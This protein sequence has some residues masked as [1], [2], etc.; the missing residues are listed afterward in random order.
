MKLKAVLF[1][2]VVLA[3]SGCQ[4]QS[5][6][7]PPTLVEQV[8]SEEAGEEQSPEA[9]P[10]EVDNSPT[11]TPLPPPD[12][13]QLGNA[14]LDWQR[15][16]INDVLLAYWDAIYYPLVRPD[17]V[18]AARLIDSPDPNFATT[19]L[20]FCDHWEA[21]DWY[22]RALPLHQHEARYFIVDEPSG[23][24]GIAVEL[25]TLGPWKSE[26]L[27]FTDGGFYGV[28]NEPRTVWR[29]YLRPVGVELKIY[30]AA[31]EDIGG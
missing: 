27:Y 11:A 26:A 16:P 14:V 7:F 15:Q 18:A 23:F 6:E 29:I 25:D 1:S 10:S 3:L 21:Q 19:V 28:A 9:L 12:Q 22:V 5:I 20:S 8:T 4:P 13:W 24:R 17:C 30:A 31:R 2:C